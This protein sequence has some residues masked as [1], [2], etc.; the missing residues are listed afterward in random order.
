MDTNPVKYGPRPILNQGPSKWLAMC[1]CSFSSSRYGWMDTIIPFSFL[2]KKVLFLE[3]CSS[4]NKFLFESSSSYII[5]NAQILNTC[6]TSTN[7]N[8]QSQLSIKSMDFLPTRAASKTWLC[9]QNCPFDAYL[10]LVV[11]PFS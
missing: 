5:S 4:W 10:N 8:L 3:S 6:I 9:C 11:T 7:S 2:K 1:I